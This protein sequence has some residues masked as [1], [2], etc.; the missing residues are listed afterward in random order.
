MG[1]HSKGVSSRPRVAG[2]LV[3]VT[4]VVAGLAAF[5]M[6][7]TASADHD[8]VEGTP[9]TTAARACVDVD[10]GQAW[11]IEDGGVVRGPVPVSTGG[12]GRET[13]RG[14]FQ[15]E[16]KN[17]DHRSTEFDGAPMPFAVFFAAGGIAF[18]EGNLHTASAGCVRMVYEDAEAWFGF[19]QVGDAVQVR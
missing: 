5:G 3:T 1:A 16:W 8:L 15:V 12:E 18:H 13:P 9:C 4:L 11:L 10:G 6:A 7:G 2:S 19:L 17:K 14:D